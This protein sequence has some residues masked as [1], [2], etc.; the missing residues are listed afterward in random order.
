MALTGVA[1]L[2][3]A[4]AAAL[5]LPRTPS[6]RSVERVAVLP[7]VV[8]GDSSLAYLR[9]G[10]VD[11]L[12]TK[13][14]A[15]GAFHAVD[16]AIV[17]SVTEGRRTDAQVE[18]LPASGAATARQVG[19]DLFI[20]GRVVGVAG[21]IELSASLFDGRGRRQALVTAV[22]NSDTPLPAA[23]DQ[24]VRDLVATRWSAPA[25]RLQR[26]A[27]TSTAS[28]E[29][30]RAYLEGERAFRAGEYTRA[31]DAF[32]AAVAAD[33]LYALAHY[34]LS[35]TAGWVAD[36]QNYQQAA[37]RALAL[38]D[39]LTE[40]DRLLVH[41]HVAYVERSADE[42]EQLYRG[43]LR[44]YPDDAEAWYNLGEVLFH[45]NPL[46][47]R[48]LAAAE[49]AFRRTEALTGHSTEALSHLYAIRL[50][51]GDLKDAATLQR[52]LLDRYPASEPRRQMYAMMDAGV[53]RD[54]VAVA[55]LLSAAGRTAGGELYILARAL[56]VYTDRLDLA[57]SIAGLL[58][59]PARP[60]ADRIAGHA[61][62][63]EFKM[64]RGQWRGAQEEAER[65]RQLD[66]ATGD[67][68]L[69]ALAT[70]PWV[71][72][73]AAEYGETRQQLGRWLPRSAS[74]RAG[75]QPLPSAQ[76]RDQLQLFYEAICALAL[77]D[78]SGVS[79][80]LLRMGRINASITGAGPVGLPLIARAAVALSRGDPAKALTLLD[81]IPPTGVMTP[82]LLQYSHAYER[83]LR[84]EALAGLGRHEEAL[85]WFRSFQVIFGFDLPYR[86][87][88][89][90]REA[91]SLEALGRQEEARG[92]YQ[93][94]LGLYADS[95]SRFEPLLRQ[96]RARIGE[97]GK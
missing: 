93:R 29:A 28:P 78:S 90:Y 40:H 91:E 30:L 97:A 34:R 69:A 65:L 71:A 67:E 62:R 76:L 23:V 72:A 83:L 56:A 6:G 33:S 54:A 18:A 41:A 77:G 17:L 52:A 38:A 31:R 89:L 66:R 95:D 55:G 16:P 8:R 24:L 13:L 57:D 46:R 81:S 45:A 73:T 75:I 1:L 51:T 12:S 92:S 59:D 53:R 19:A 11:L 43:I 2:V 85:G 5:L 48:P 64:A 58:R 10:L 84:G 22:A 3:I 44:Q 21:A 4:V 39:R 25:D 60:P 32:L 14:D 37:H 63:V 27:V 86:A 82:D 88:A 9:E 79:Q 94:F 74:A 50:L 26:L 36:G 80:V 42:A 47:G 15:L 61:L 87:P 7:F 96:A 68:V 70:L 35:V 49:V 20:L